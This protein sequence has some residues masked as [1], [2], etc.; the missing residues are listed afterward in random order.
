MNAKSSGIFVEHWSHIGDVGYSIMRGTPL[1]NPFKIGE[2]GSR[3]QVIAKYRSYL[4]RAI[5]GH[6]LTICTEL[7]RLY[8]IW[9]DKGILT[10]KC[11]CRPEACH[12]DVIKACLEWIRSKMA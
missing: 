2:D 12:G 3:E 5:Q 4:W 1:G 7:N 10:L 6:E 11:C 8:K 9:Q